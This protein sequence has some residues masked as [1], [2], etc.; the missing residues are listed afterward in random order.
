MN[1]KKIT[2]IVI[3]QLLSFSVLCQIKNPFFEKRG[4]KNLSITNIDVFSTSTLVSFEYKVPSNKY[5]NG[6][7]ICADKFFIKDKKTNKKYNLIDVI[8]I[9]ICPNKKEF[10]FEKQN[11]EFKLIFEPLPAKTE[12]IDIIDNKTNT[13]FSFYGIR[14][15]SKIK[16]KNIRKKSIT[17]PKIIGYKKVTMDAKMR[18]SNDVLSKVILNIRKG[19]TV[20]IINKKKNGYI[21]IKY[22]GRIGFINEIY[23]QKRETKIPKS[24]V[25]DDWRFYFKNVKRKIHDVEGIYNAGY[26]I[27]IDHDF[28]NYYAKRIYR[29]AI[30]VIYKQR[31]LLK[32]KILN[33]FHKGNQLEGIDIS[34]FT[35]FIFKPTSS[36]NVFTGKTN[37]ISSNYSVDYI[38]RYENEII[39]FNYI[40]PK[41]YTIEKNFENKDYNEHIFHEWIKIYP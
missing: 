21:K 31:D 11:F 28:E 23:L 39:K 8:N 4:D 6:G 40:V 25:E 37:Y 14:L 12:F 5:I 15:V 26:T 24:N 27:E 3:I 1:Y 22:Q 16:T 35:S 18:S 19:E 36:K 13:N 7:W 32:V 10:E 30:I 9:P 41:G 33:T 2:L 17:K 29:P 38:V 20:Q 34:K